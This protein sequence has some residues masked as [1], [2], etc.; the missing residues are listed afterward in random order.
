M[1]MLQNYGI[2]KL[3]GKMVGLNTMLILGYHVVL[4]L[5]SLIWSRV[6]IASPLQIF[7]FIWGFYSCTL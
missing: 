7:V 3:S 4:L 5:A 6:C 1:H 2:N